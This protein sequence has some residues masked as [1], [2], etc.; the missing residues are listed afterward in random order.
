LIALVGV[1]L[2]CGDRVIE[3]EPEDFTEEVERICAD[4]CEI[5]LACR[6]EPV[7][8]SHQE[9]EQVC[10]HLAY[11][12]NDTP[13]GEATRAVKECIGSQPTCDLY[14]DTLNVHAE[15]YTCKAEKDHWVSL[16]ESCGQ[17]DEDPYPY[18]EP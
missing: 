14:N 12:Y 8:D 18:G 15:Q 4:Y 5:Y 1:A 2:S 9:C 10:L 6:E 7:F 13:C 16:A 17:S 3:P 11:I